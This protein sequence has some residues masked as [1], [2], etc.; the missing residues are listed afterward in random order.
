MAATESSVLVTSSAQNPALEQ[1]TMIV[2]GNLAGDGD[3]DVDTRG[4]I[5]G[6]LNININSSPSARSFRT[7]WTLPYG[8]LEGD[9]ILSDG[10]PSESVPLTNPKTTKETDD[11]EIEFKFDSDLDSNGNVGDSDPGKDGEDLG[12][13]STSRRLMPDAGNKSEGRPDSDFFD[14]FNTI[15]QDGTAFYSICDPSV[16]DEYLCFR[17]DSD[18]ET[19]TVG[20]LDCQKISYYN[21]D[22]RCPNNKM[23]V[24]RRDTLERLFEVDLTGNIDSNSSSTTTTSMPYTTT[25]CRTIETRL[26]KTDRMVLP[27]EESAWDFSYCLRYNFDEAPAVEGGSYAPS[28][29]EMEIDGI[30]CT[31]CLL[32]F[33]D[34]MDAA[35]SSNGDGDGDGTTTQ[36][37]CATFDCGNTLLGYSGRFCNEANLASNSIDYF[38]Y[39]SLPCDG[40]CNLCGDRTEGDAESM[41]MM[42]FRDSDFSAEVDTNGTE[43]TSLR[44]TGNCFEDQWEALMGYTQDFDCQA[45]RP[46]VREA[47]GCTPMGGIPNGTVDEMEP[48]TASSSSSS[49]STTD[50]ENVASG[51]IAMISTK[52]SVHVI[53]ATLAAVLVVGLGLV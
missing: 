7:Q 44:V 50:D 49:E 4:G 47:C 53:T 23:V 26:T 17:C 37:I 39:R 46:A 31:S 33:I 48:N 43:F 24:S 28:T 3:G 27:D 20:D 9:E 15:D 6:N 1:S 52:T 32:E 5:T 13:L 19:K 25:R 11:T 12:I 22:S 29:C 41:M 36:E 21:V 51:A 45:K 30:V 10:H 14:S 38:I 35:S 34:V 16:E 18:P 42:K 2:E 8:P 40:G